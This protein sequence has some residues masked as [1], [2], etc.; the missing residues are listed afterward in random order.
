[1]GK[2]KGER[3]LADALAMIA[4][5]RDDFRVS[6]LGFGGEDFAQYCERAGI[7]RFV[8]FLGP[9][10]PFERV[11]YFERADIFCLPTHAEA[12]PMSVI[13]AM[14]AG[15]AI[16]STT[17]GGIP[18]LVDNDREGL[19]VAPGDISGLAAKLGDLLGNRERR[20]ELGRAARKKAGRHSDFELYSKK[21]GETL[22]SVISDSNSERAPRAGGVSSERLGNE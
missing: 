18:E 8:E 10:P 19:L 13:E 5:T 14:T 20:L 12:M 21:L 16:V 9:V 22:A 11:P 6:F 4:K 15:L 17:V 7:E 1:M 3:D 2:L